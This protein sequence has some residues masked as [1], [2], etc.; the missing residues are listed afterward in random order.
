MAT[1]IRPAHAPAAPPTK[2]PDSTFTRNLRFEWASE[3]GRALVGS[4]MIS[5]G[6]GLAFLL[7]VHLMPVRQAPPEDEP[8]PVTMADTLYQEQPAP[9]PPPVAQVGEATRTPAPGPT[10]KKEGPVG[11]QKGNPKPGRPGSLTE[12]NS[13]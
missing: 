3:E 9:E 2:R 7:L 5:G 11:P 1:P 13:T 4:Y 6:L 10:T 8:V 12:T